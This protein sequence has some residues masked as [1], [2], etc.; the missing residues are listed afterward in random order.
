M[1]CRT[2]VMPIIL[3]PPKHRPRD[4]R[5]TLFT[6]AK[7]K[8]GRPTLFTNER[9]KKIIKAVSEGN[10]LN[11]AAQ[12]AGIDETTLW[13]WL[14]RGKKEGEGEYFEFLQSVMEAEHEAEKVAV[15]AVRLA[16]KNDA[17]HFQWW[18]ERK[19]P[20]RWGK[21]TF[22][23]KQLQAEVD[24]M[25]AEMQVLIADKRYTQT[26]KPHQPDEPVPAEP[27]SGEAETDTEGSA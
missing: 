8:T 10:Y 12:A 7:A 4:T 23:V 3:L 16:G 19:C 13:N 26:E 22:Q 6:M 2:S 9:R 1:A 20:E 27:G 24:K 21:D 11:V 15:R 25:K 5:V 17:K 18:L 14:R